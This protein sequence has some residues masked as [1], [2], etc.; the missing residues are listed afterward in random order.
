MVSSALQEHNDGSTMSHKADKI[1]CSFLLPP[2][3]TFMD[4]TDKHS[5]IDAIID[6]RVENAERVLSEISLLSLPSREQIHSE[7]EEELLLPKAKLP[8]HWLPTYQM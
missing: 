5:L 3:M 7:I 1:R 4:A 8:A 6:P 2:L